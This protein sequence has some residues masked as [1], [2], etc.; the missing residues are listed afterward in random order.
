MLPCNSAFIFSN[1]SLQ[2]KFN[3]MRRLSGCTHFNL[4]CMH[5]DNTGHQF[6][7]IHEW[8]Q[9]SPFKAVQWTK[10]KN[11]LSSSSPKPNLASEERKLCHLS[12]IADCYRR[13]FKTWHNWKFFKWT[14]RITIIYKTTEKHSTLK[15]K[16][17]CDFQPLMQHKHTLQCQFLRVT[18]EGMPLQ[19]LLQHMP[20]ITNVHCIGVQFSIEAKGGNK[21]FHTSYKKG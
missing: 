5:A 16:L 4:P 10:R 3:N 13:Q 6:A 9:D 15:K 14:W 8:T 11:L 12:R 18:H 21:S 1:A 17:Q 2:R 7:H 20:A 19:T